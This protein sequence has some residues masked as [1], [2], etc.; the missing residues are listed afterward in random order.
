MLIVIQTEKRRTVWEFIRRGMTSSTWKYQWWG[1]ELHLGGVCSS[2]WLCW[3]RFC[4]CSPCGSWSI[5]TGDCGGF[6]HLQAGVWGQGT[7]HMLDQWWSCTA[8]WGVWSDVCAVGL[9]ISVIGAC[10]QHLK[11]SC[12]CSAWRA[13][14]FFGSSQG[15][16]CTCHCG[17]PTLFMHTHW[18]VGSV[19]C[20]KVPRSWLGLLILL[21]PFA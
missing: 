6:F 9:T 16:R 15:W 14:P 3:G 1:T 13:L 5:G 12:V 21:E 18:W 10:L 19:P 7:S 11:C 4:F 17:G 8:W 20:R 2:P